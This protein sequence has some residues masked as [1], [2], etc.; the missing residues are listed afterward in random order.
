VTSR[1][2]IL[3]ALAFVSLV[4][5]VQGQT[6]Y[7]WNYGTT[8][9]N[10]LPST[11]SNPNLTV[12]A[13]TH[14]QARGS[15]SGPTTTNASSGYFGATGQYN[16]GASAFSGAL[17][18]ATSTYLAFS[19]TPTNGSDGIVISNI[20]FA[21]RSNQNGSNNGPT[22]ITI[23]SSLDGY[24]SDIVTPISV[25][26]FDTWN[27]FAPSITTSTFA[28]GADTPVTFRIYGYSGSGNS[29]NVDWQL[30]D[31]AITITP[32][33]EPGTM[34]GLGAAVLALGAFVRRRLV[35]SNAVAVA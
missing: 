25:S 19:V 22:A 31:F 34:F 7:A 15:N 21:S 26:S 11:G 30:D 3:A 4:S 18:P 20:S 1:I 24:A 10:T 28:S 9:A 17:N 32:V 27:F 23:R 14:G 16:Y 33:P 6:P 13:F 8:T 2:S 35:R 29:A 12:S 5:T